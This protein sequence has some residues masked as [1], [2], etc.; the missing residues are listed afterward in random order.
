MKELDAESTLVAMAIGA[1]LL[2]ILDRFYFKSLGTGKA[3]AGGALIGFFVQTGER[4]S[5]A[6]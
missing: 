6:S 3:L 4:F 1:L 5:G 2:F